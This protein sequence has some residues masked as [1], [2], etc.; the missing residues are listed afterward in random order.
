MTNSEIKNCEHKQTIVVDN[1]VAEW[2]E[3]CGAFRVKSGNPWRWGNWYFPRTPEPTK[4]ENGL[5]KLDIEKVA[6]LYDEF[7]EGA[8]EEGVFDVMK[9]STLLCSRFGTPSI[10]KEQLLAILPEEMPPTS[11]WY[12]GYMSYRQVLLQ[13]IE[14][15]WK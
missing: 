7:Y 4:A 12:M 1:A 2:C 8:T 14:E 6:D 9:F 3:D 5:V 13:R 11:D 10:T 15:L